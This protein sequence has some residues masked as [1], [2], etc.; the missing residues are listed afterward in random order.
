MYKSSHVLF[1][2]VWQIKASRACRKGTT[3]INLTDS[4]FEFSKGENIIEFYKKHGKIITNAAV[5]LLVIVAIAIKTGEEGGQVLFRA[6][7]LYL[8]AGAVLAFI[9][10]RMFTKKHQQDQGRR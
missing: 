6:D 4:S 2:G 3:V 10:L 5:A 8:L 9:L 1:Y 7:D